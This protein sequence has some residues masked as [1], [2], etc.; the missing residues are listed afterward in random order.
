[1]K[2]SELYDHNDLAPHW[3]FIAECRRIAAV[4]PL[5]DLDVIPYYESNNI[6]ILERM[7]INGEIFV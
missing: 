4:R 5:T 3:D 6:P 2:Y 7:A 1:M